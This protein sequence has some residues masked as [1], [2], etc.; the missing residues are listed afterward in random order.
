MSNRSKKA[1][2]SRSLNNKKS[3]HIGGK[4][5]KVTP[6]PLKK[7]TSVLD[8]CSTAEIHS[9]KE[10]IAQRLGCNVLFFRLKQL[11]ECL[12][13][14][15]NQF[16][17]DL[18]IPEEKLSISE[19]IISSQEHFL[20][21]KSIRE[22]A[23]ANNADFNH[24]LNYIEKA[25]NIITTNRDHLLNVHSALKQN[26]V[27]ENILSDDNHVYKDWAA[28]FSPLLKIIH[29][30]T[31]KELR[32]LK[33]YESYLISV[34]YITEE[35]KD[36]SDRIP[37]NLDLL[38]ICESVIAD[39]FNNCCNFSLILEKIVV[40]RQFNNGFSKFVK[41]LNLTASTII[42]ETRND[43]S[44]QAFFIGVLNDVNTQIR[45]KF[46]VDNISIPSPDVYVS[47][48]DC[49]DTNCCSFIDV[50]K[51]LS[52]LDLSNDPL[53]AESLR[54]VYCDFNGLLQKQ[55]IVQKQLIFIDPPMEGMTHDDNS[56]LTAKMNLLARIE[57]LASINKHINFNW[58]K[59]KLNKELFW[60]QQQLN[61]ELRQKK[62]Q[63]NDLSPE[64][65]DVK[66][67]YDFLYGIIN[68][69]DA[70]AV[71]FDE[72]SSLLKYQ[73]SCINLLAK[74][75]AFYT[76][77]IAEIGT[78]LNNLHEAEDV[79]LGLFKSLL[80]SL[81]YQEQVIHLNNITLINN[82]AENYLYQHLGI[83]FNIDL[84]S[85]TANL[86]KVITRFTRCFIA[87]DYVFARFMVD[88]YHYKPNKQTELD[89][90]LNE[91]QLKLN[92]KLMHLD[93]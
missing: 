68:D 20:C 35:S 4:S 54:E 83:V 47:F 50:D 60:D 18:Q 43:Q 49:F 70:F 2:Y 11:A 21:E 5:E 42:D 82:V 80:F 22:F 51:E 8:N 59:Q 72:S 6:P 33:Q 34:F 12:E 14:D 74:E 58:N 64:Y 66:Q 16:N 38:A 10:L 15:I 26:I 36:T 89:K 56:Y 92:A 88:A 45:E 7:P 27:V 77:T 9:L 87:D 69:D 19:K 37:S 17:L 28:A 55:R 90:L 62:E 32:L 48:D 13:S 81:F 61:Q 52:Q 57:L 86:F 85:T 84:A 29:Y 78:Y 25:N 41:N 39:T 75:R 53:L 63:K 46:T 73:L 31:I 79:D 71:F 67:V 40:Q 24:T 3:I 1:Q 23:A 30:M 65:G 76:N 44:Q 91:A 93:Y